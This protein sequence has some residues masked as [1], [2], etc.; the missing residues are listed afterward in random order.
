MCNSTIPR[1]LSCPVLCPTRVN[2]GRLL[3]AVAALE[4]FRNFSFAKNN[5]TTVVLARELSQYIPAVEGV[6]VKCEDD[7]VSWCAAHRD[8]LPFWS[9]IFKKLLLT[10]PSSATAER[11]IS[12]L[13]STFNAQQDSALQDYI[14]DCDASIQKDR[15]ETNNSCSYTVYCLQFCDAAYSRNYA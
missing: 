12:L 13:S 2:R 7:K 10:Q 3:A 5:A 9:A 15:R 4:E 1:E 8:I 14:E 6:T 11:V